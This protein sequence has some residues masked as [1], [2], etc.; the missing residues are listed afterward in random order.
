MAWDDPVVWILIVGAVIL[1]FGSKKIPQIA[2]SLGAA[3]KEFDNARKGLTTAINTEINAA[4]SQNI[5]PGMHRSDQNVPQTVSEPSPPVEVDTVSQEETTPHLSEEGTVHR[6][7]EAEEH[8]QAVNDTTNDDGA[9][10]A[11]HAAAPSH[12]TLNRGEVRVLKASSPAIRSSEAFAE[13]A[14][15]KMFVRIDPN[16]QHQRSQRS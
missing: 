13:E 8:T 2:R 7:G 12:N 14:G 6:S 1:L 15:P 16:S 9:A 10:E 5:P 4:N 11:D 3:R